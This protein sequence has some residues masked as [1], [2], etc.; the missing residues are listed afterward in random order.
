MRTPLCLV[1]AVLALP[2]GASCDL[3]LGGR[4]CIVQSLQLKRPFLYSFCLEVKLFTDT[5]W[6]KRSFSFLPG[7]NSGVSGATHPF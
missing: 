5:V 7:G 6:K 4:G 3:S 2:K 1:R